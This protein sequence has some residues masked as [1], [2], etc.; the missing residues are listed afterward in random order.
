MKGDCQES[1]HYPNRGDSGSLDTAG[2]GV[3]GRARGVLGP[4]PIA[5]T[6]FGGRGKTILVK[7]YAF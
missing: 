3:V 5:S 6:D 7:R 1:A 2:E 4:E